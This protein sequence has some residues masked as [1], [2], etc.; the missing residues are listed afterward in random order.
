MYLKPYSAYLW[1]MPRRDL[2]FLRRA[3]AM[4]A[5]ATRVEE[6]LWDELRGGQLG[7]RFRRQEPIGPYIVDLVCKARRLVVEVDGDSHQDDAADEA[8]DRH[9]R[10]M[11]YRVI[12]FTNPEIYQDRHDMV[13]WLWHRLHPEDGD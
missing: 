13:D 5:E 2:R 4:R 7:F 12:R 3:R 11:G 6:I 8:R 9:L 10:A 1:S